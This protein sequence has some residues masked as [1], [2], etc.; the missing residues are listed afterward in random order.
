MH[1]ARHLLSPSM[2][3]GHGVRTLGTDEIAYNPLSYHN[4]SIWPHDNSL[5]AAGLRIYDR[6]RELQL[7]AEGAL[8]VLEASDD[9]RL[10]ELFC[11]F[12]KYGNGAPVPYDVACKPQAWA[13]GSLFLLLR[14]LLGMCA[15]C[16]SEDLQFTTPILPRQIPSLE[17]QG[18]PFKGQILNFVVR[19]GQYISTVELTKR[20]G[21]ARLNICT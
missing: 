8:G 11:G 4:G 5:I 18:L 10:P 19:Q 12:P 15:S 2:F 14:S 21:T 9:F 13:A 7:L 1:I 16:D 20:S 3:S 17:V 6:H